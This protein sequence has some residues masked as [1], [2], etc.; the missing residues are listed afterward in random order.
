[1]DR[2]KR[3]FRVIVA[4]VLLTGL[5]IIWLDERLNGSHEPRDCV[6]DYLRSDCR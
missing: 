4:L 3:R 6:T 5:S 2:E 1:M